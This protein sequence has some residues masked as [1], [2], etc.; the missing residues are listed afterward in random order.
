[1]MKHELDFVCRA[2][3]SVNQIKSGLVSEICFQEK[4]NIDQISRLLGT[5]SIPYHV[6]VIL[7]C[8]PKIEAKS[9]PKWISTLMPWK[10]VERV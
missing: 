7:H 9:S 8:S 2:L 1:M 5:Y 3:D 4:E 10:L 6:D